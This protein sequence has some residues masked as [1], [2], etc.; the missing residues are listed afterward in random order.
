MCIANNHYTLVW[1]FTHYLVV[2]WWWLN[3]DQT[4][5]TIIEWLLIE[6]DCWYIVITLKMVNYISFCISYKLCSPSLIVWPFVHVIVILFIITIVLKTSVM[7]FNISTI[8]NVIYWECISFLFHWCGLYP[9][10]V[11]HTR[12][13]TCW[14][15]TEL[16]QELGR[17]GKEHG[18]Q[19]IP[20]WRDK[21]LEGQIVLTLLNIG[22]NKID[23]SPASLNSIFSLSNIL[24]HVIKCIVPSCSDVIAYCECASVN[25]SI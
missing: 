18:T 6:N 19:N 7:H 22:S 25:L 2:Y 5:R 4:I 15:V 24:S 1:L 9:G 11:C 13:A 17:R 23:K 20:Q 3:K 21:I 12:D 14:P 10:S 16:V 8:W